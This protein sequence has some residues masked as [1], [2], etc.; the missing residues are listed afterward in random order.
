MTVYWRAQGEA[1]FESVTA[2]ASGDTFTAEIPDQ[3][4]GTTIEY[5]VTTRLSDGTELVYP[6]NPADPDYAFYVGPLVPVYCT[7]FESD[8]T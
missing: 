2:T 6:Q 3:P 5:R 4:D 7:D 1:A 8:P